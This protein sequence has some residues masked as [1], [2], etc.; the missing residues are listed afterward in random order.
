MY[1]KIIANCD[2]IEILSIQ[3]A[4]E[5]KFSFFF[6]ASH[7]LTLIIALSRL[8]KRV[9][10][11][12]SRGTIIFFSSK[13]ALQDSIHTNVQRSHQVSLMIIVDMRNVV[14]RNN[15][16]RLVSSVMIMTFYFRQK[17]RKEI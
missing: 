13:L 17:F 11:S 12:S 8:Q 4:L 15:L 1:G 9:T 16:N 5:P 7:D 10:H 14:L 6:I 3:D 2:K